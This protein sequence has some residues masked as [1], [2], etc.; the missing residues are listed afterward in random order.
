MLLRRHYP[1]AEALYQRL[2]PVKAA[3]DIDRLLVEAGILEGL[4][5]AA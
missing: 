2:R 5:L 1:E 3:E 4:P